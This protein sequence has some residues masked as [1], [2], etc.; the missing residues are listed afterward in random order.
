MLRICSYLKRITDEWIRRL[1]DDDT[2]T[3]VNSVSE[4]RFPRSIE[5]QRNSVFIITDQTH[6]SLELRDVEDY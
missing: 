1:D 3:E 6:T 4:F 5:I 2:L